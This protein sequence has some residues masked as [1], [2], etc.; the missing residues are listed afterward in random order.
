M[1]IMS[2]F[3]KPKLSFF[4]AMRL[5]SLNKV[6]MCRKRKEKSKPRQNPTADSKVPYCT[7]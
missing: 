5:G 7:R 1:K 2:N 3:F 6:K 4:D